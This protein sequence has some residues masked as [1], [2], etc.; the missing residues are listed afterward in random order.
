MAVKLRNIKEIQITNEKYKKIYK[1][2]QKGINYQINRY[3]ELISTKVCHK[4]LN[5][6]DLYIPRN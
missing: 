5:Q 2:D 1:K 4:W 6:W 3:Y